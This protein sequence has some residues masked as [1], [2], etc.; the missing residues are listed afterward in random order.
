[1]VEI[2]KVGWFGNDTCRMNGMAQNCFKFQRK[3]RYIFSEDQRNTVHIYAG[4]FGDHFGHIC[5]IFRGLQSVIPFQIP[6]YMQDFPGTAVSY[7][8]PNS[9]INAGIFRGLQSVI[10]CQSPAYLYRGIPGT[11]I[12]YP[13]Q[14]SGIY[15][16]IFL[17][18]QSVIPCK[19]QACM[20]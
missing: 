9:G 8:L 4:K 2:L 14:N 15:A 13:L 16:G 7:P 12:S 20:Q 17:G 5:R 11:S 19:I 18:L 1:M 3:F 10:P 6:A